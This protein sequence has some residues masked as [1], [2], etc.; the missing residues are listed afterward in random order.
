[1]INIPPQNKCR[2]T[3]RNLKEVSKSQIL[4]L[5]LVPSCVHYILSRF[6]VLGCPDFVLWVL[7]TA[8]FTIDFM[9]I[10]FFSSI[11]MNGI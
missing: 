5:Q 11:S 10:S 8:T 2:Q 6:C 4:T 9:E 1:M 3:A 7:S